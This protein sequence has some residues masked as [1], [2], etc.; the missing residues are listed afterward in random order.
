MGSSRVSSRVNL[1]FRLIFSA[2]CRRVVMSTLL[3]VEGAVVERFA[4]D[5][6]V[7]K[8][9]CANLAIAIAKK[10]EKQLESRLPQ[11]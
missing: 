10:E 6:A 11:I 8:A 3:E 5:T 2:C 7:L 1:P 4:L 9:K